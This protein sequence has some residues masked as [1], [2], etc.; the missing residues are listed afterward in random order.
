MNTTHLLWGALLLFSCTTEQSAQEKTAPANE[1]QKIY[2][3]DSSSY[4]V[5]VYMN[6]KKTGWWKSYNANGQLLSEDLYNREEKLLHERLTDGQLTSA[7]RIVTPGGE[8]VISYHPNGR[9]KFFGY[10]TQADSSAPKILN[11]DA[12]D[13]DSTGVLRLHSHYDVSKGLVSE[14]EYNAMGQLFQ[15]RYFNVP[16]PSCDKK[17]TGTWKTYQ[18]GKLE[19]TTRY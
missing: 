15:E 9:L 2:A 10:F 6:N 8:L 17:P 12:R 1:Q 13:F 19:K 3:A 5:G 11:G 16:C 4:S 18:N 7:E 14:K